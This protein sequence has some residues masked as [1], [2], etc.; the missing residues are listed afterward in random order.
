MPELPEVENVR[1][2]LFPILIGKEIIS[3]EVLR[4]QNIDT[5]LPYFLSTLPHKRFVDIQRKGKYLLFKLDNGDTL[6]AHLRMEGKFFVEEENEEPAKHD[7][8]IFHLSGDQ[9]LVYNDSRRFGRMGLYNEESLKLSPI[10]KLGKEPSEFEEGEF[11]T[12]LKGKHKPIKEVLLDQTLIAGIGNIYADESLFASKIN[13]F[14]KASSLS[15]EQTSALLKNIQSI[16]ERAISL[17]GSTIR[18]YHP[19]EGVSGS[20]QNNLKVYG[21]AGTPC[22]NCSFPL[23]KET[24]GGRGTTYCPHCQVKEGGKLVIGVCG[25]IHSGKSTFSGYLKEKGF[26]VFDADKEVRI[27]YAQRRVQRHLSFLFGDEVIKNGLVDFTY[28]RLA[29]SKGE[30]QKEELDS[31]LYPLVKQRAASFITRQKKGS[32]IVLDVPLLFKAKMDDLC[33]ATVLIVAKQEN[34]EKRLL[35]EGRDAKAL[36]KVNA[37]YPLEEASQKASFIIEN[38]GDVDDFKKKIDALPFFNQ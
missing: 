25:P 19:K 15:K 4:G 32:K 3:V 10:S 31:Y 28:L 11:A 23:K 14:T 16:L 34:R 5:P 38:N 20:M 21:K 17:G 37:D 12:L 8:I 2:A 26:L 36:L 6:L 1:L 24:L 7:L 27:L 30:K 18:S 13:P 22:P 29:L 9:K 35:K 33:E